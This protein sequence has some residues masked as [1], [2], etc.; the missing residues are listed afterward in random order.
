MSTFTTRPTSDV[1]NNAAITGTPS[2]SAGNKYTNID[3]ATLNESDYLEINCSMSG[4]DA[5]EEYGFANH[6]TEDD[7]ISSVVLKVYAKKVMSGTQNATIEL[8]LKIGS[9]QYYG[10]VNSEQLTTTTAIYSRTFALNPSNSSAWTWSD[11]DALVAR[12]HITGD[13]TDKNNYASPTYYQMWIEVE[14]GEG[15]GNAK[16]IKVNGVW[17]AISSTQIKVGGVW[18]SVSANKIKVG[19]SWK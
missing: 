12:I 13:R 5:F 9:T 8:S 15:G 17:R 14:H 11:I 19:G 7:D 18:K 3:E 4:G 16:M 2:V 1:T 6:T 10:G